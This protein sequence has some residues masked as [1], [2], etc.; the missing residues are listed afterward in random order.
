MKHL[1]ITTVTTAI[2]ALGVGV[3]G[4][5]AA[6][7]AQGSPGPPEVPWG[8]MHDWGTGGFW[9]MPLVMMAWFAALVAVIILLVRWLGAGPALEVRRAA[10][11]ATFSMSV[12]H[13]ARSIKKNTCNERGTFGENDRGLGTWR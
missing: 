1:S 2:A 6:I 3:V 10:R 5:P 11:R 8:M 13:A 7:W 4:V 12:M 9:L